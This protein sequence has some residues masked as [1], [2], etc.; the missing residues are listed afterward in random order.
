MR[1]SG[2][3][4][5]L[6]YCFELKTGFEVRCLLPAGQKGLSELGSGAG[7]EPG[8]QPGG[9]EASGAGEQGPRAGAASSESTMAGLGAAGAL[10]GGP[11]P[12]SLLGPGMALSAALGEAG[13]GRGT[14]PTHTDPGSPGGSRWCSR[15]RSSPSRHND[16]MSPRP[17]TAAQVHTR[18]GDYCHKILTQDPN[19]IIVSHLSSLWSEN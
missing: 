10:A 11:I 2:S 3:Q 19:L 7:E 18:N 14:A 15:R 13:A 1:C 5:K 8:D 12:A 9:Q 16:P 4:D 17:G 6:G